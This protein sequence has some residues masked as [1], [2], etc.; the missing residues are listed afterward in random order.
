ML[1]QSS[2]K[3]FL[4]GSPLFKH[5]ECVLPKQIERLQMMHHFSLKE[6]YI[7]LEMCEHMQNVH[8]T[9]EHLHS[10]LSNSIEQMKLLKC[11]CSHKSCICP[12]SLLLHE[13][14]YFLFKTAGLPQASI[15]FL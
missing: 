13:L 4:N 14:F 5:F 12:P 8:F 1:I 9:K 10:L 11:T 15:H 6:N 3:Y 7:T 2:C